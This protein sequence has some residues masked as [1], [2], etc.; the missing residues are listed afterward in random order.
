MYSNFAAHMEI[1]ASNDYEYFYPALDGQKVVFSV[2][3]K[4]NTIKIVGNTKIV[5]AYVLV[6]G[7]FESIMMNNTTINM[8]KLDYVYYQ[9]KEISSFFNREIRSGCLVTVNAILSISSP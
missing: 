4:S 1:P 5:K 9:V 7:R 3:D 2:A 8:D 6:S